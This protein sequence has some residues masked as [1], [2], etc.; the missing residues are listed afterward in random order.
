MSLESYWN[1]TESEIKPPVIFF[2]EQA[3]TLAKVTNGILNG[4]VEIYT[5][6]NTIQ[7]ELWVTAPLLNNYKYLL[8][9]ALHP[10]SL[11]PVALHIIPKT[12]KDRN[13]N[14]VSERKDCQNEQE[15]DAALKS[16]LSSN[17]VAKVIQS[18]LAMSKSS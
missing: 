13:G 8:L 14:E 9:K 4:E 10:L 5:F 7:S 6:E 2:R 12:V 18:L 3:R 16:A 11:Y 1:I 17:E 15:F